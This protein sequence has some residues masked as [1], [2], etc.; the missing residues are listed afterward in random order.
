MVK[1]SGSSGARP[2]ANG[3]LMTK[4]RQ[5]PMKHPQLAQ[6]EAY[7]EALRG[8]RS[9]PLRSEIDPRGIDT[10][11][12]YA[13]ILE[14]IEPGMCRFRLAGMHLNELMGMEVRGMPLR[15]FFAPE[16]R[17]RV[18]QSLEHVFEE[19]AK[20][21][22]HVRSTGENGDALEGQMI[23]LPLR[24]DLGDFSRALGAF[25]TTGRRGNAPHRFMLERC[26]IR[27]LSGKPMDLDG[28]VPR[29]VPPRRR[30]PGLRD[31]PGFAEPR[32]RFGA[33][34]GTGAASGDRGGHL[35]LVHDAAR[36]DTP[37]ERG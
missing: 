15:A 36:D 2:A 24:S 17:E 37:G 26:D 35:R 19:P 28:A 23:L 13:F 4:V 8:E 31:M 21:V 6:V 16:A 7:W 1:F 11:L 20:A 18:A 12:E 30:E 22:H 25:A 29:A 10:A 34:P 27:A 3:P 33:A 32:H 9:A 5:I 14:R